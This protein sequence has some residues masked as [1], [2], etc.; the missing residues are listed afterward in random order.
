MSA[1]ETLRRLPF[2]SSEEE[3]F[4]LFD[5]GPVE[6]LGRTFDAAVEVEDG[7]DH[8]VLVNLTSQGDDEADAREAL[9]TETLEAVRGRL[10]EVGVTVPVEDVTWLA[11]GVHTNSTLQ[12]AVVFET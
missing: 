6:A 11:S 2:L 3:G 7:D 8:V 9:Y 1:I 12:A 10:A 4:A 5:L